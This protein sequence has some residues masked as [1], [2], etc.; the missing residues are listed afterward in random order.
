LFAGILLSPVLALIQWHF[1]GVK[2]ALSL[3]ALLAIVP[4]AAIVS[5]ATEQVAERMSNAL[6][7][8]RLI[9][10]TP[11]TELSL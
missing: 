2:F 4:L 3:V 9:E 7:L 1:P 8:S 11:I 6:I 10:P 5:H